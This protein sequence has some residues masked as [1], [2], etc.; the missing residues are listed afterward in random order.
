MSFKKYLSLLL[1]VCLCVSFFPIS[2]MGYEGEENI[3]K[4]VE[5]TAS[6]VY[7]SPPSDEAA[8]S[9]MSANGEGEVAQIGEMGYP[10]LSAAIA[11]VSG[12]S[13]TTITLL[14]NIEERVKIESTKNIR[15]DLNGHTISGSDEVIKNMGTLEM[16]GLIEGSGIITS[17]VCAVSNWGGTGSLTVNGGHYKS[18]LNEMTE[19]LMENGLFSFYFTDSNKGIIE[20]VQAVSEHTIFYSGSYSRINVNNCSVIKE[21]QTDPEDSK[22]SP[23][24]RISDS[25]WIEICG[26]IYTSDNVDNED[27]S[28]FYAGTG[29]ITVNSGSFT[30]NGDGIPLIDG[31]DNPNTIYINGGSFAGQ[32]EFNHSEYVD[33]E[34]MGG[35]Y[36]E[37]LASDI[38]NHPAY[39]ASGYQLYDNTDSDSATYTK[40]VMEANQYFKVGDENFRNFSDAL[41]KAEETASS[42]SHVTITMLQNYSEAVSYT[43]DQDDDGIILDL[44]GHTY[45]I[46]PYNSTNCS[47]TVSSG[48]DLTLRDSSQTGS[49]C[50]K[51]GHFA[52]TLYV[53]DGGKFTLDG[54]HI[55]GNHALYIGEGSEVHLN[56]GTVSTENSG[57]PLAVWGRATVFIDTAHVSLIQTSHDYYYQ[58]LSKRD[59]GF[60]PD[61]YATKNT[62]M[63]YTVS[64]GDNNTL[65]WGNATVN[66]I[67]YYHVIEG[68][69]STVAEVSVPGGTTGLYTSLAEAFNA[70]SSAAQEDTSKIVTV[71]L[72]K[73]FGTTGEVYNIPEQ[74]NGYAKIRFDLNGHTLTSTLTMGKFIDL[75]VRDSCLSG[76]K[77]IGAPCVIVKGSYKKF[78]LLS[79]KLEIAGFPD[80]SF[81]GANSVDPVAAGIYMD[82]DPA[83]SMTGGTIQLSDRF[84]TTGADTVAGIYIKGAVDTTSLTGGM[85]DVTANN[86]SIDTVGVDV[87]NSSYLTIGSD[88]NGPEI[89]ANTNAI[90]IGSG[91]NF[92]GSYLIKGG[93]LSSRKSSAILNEGSVLLTVEGKTAITGTTAL[94]V[95]KGLLNIDG[96]PALTGTDGSAVHIN[97]SGGTVSEIKFSG[98]PTFTSAAGYEQ[99]KVTPKSNEDTIP[100]ILS[101][102]NNYTVTSDYLWTANTDSNTNAKYPFKVSFAKPVITR[103]SLV[104]ASEIGVRFRVSFPENYNTDECR[105]DFEVVDGRTESMSFEKAQKIDNTN[106]YY[107]TCYINALELAEDI[108]ATLYYG[109]NQ[110][111]ED[112][113]SAMSY[114]T[115]VQQNMADNKELLNL[116]NA[117]QNYGYYMQQSGW[118]DDKPSHT[119]ILMKDELNTASID[120]AKDGV[121]NMKV[122]KELENSGITDAKFALSLNEKTS[123]RVS[124]K[125]D[126]ET[127]ILTS[128]GKK[129]T[130]NDETYYQFTTEKFGA[131]YLA[132]PYTVTVVTDKGTASVT[133][134]AMSYVHAILNGDFNQNEQKAMTAYYYYYKAADEYSKSGN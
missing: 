11:A 103:H 122:I 114:I 52:T 59:N 22:I 10:T 95:T 42:G 18:T 19:S 29:R 50:L 23:I 66:S 132:N 32:G 68:N 35:K 91:C 12:D 96:Q 49:G 85:I 76:G 24:F 128:G 36:S 90:R 8:A 84:D 129:R 65:I 14:Q 89:I 15:L 67:D 125:P 75:T 45:T 30:L 20:N 56:N 119:D 26:G 99:I 25:S 107:F 87:I 94:E 16:E 39:F 98:K 118:K 27:N 41:R 53:K 69:Q 37:I 3:V 93:C 97:H 134:S 55:N 115:N 31:A 57:Y 1:A 120:E 110:S 28:L 102:V 58:I 81:S 86:P 113:Y 21:A 48:G 127:T 54:A 6:E 82:G 47:F 124:F 72:L 83:V 70:A 111:L 5:K 126:N 46:M 13:Q 43:F 44:Y 100:A 7:E 73:D 117:L 64:G 9:L 33:V 74:E 92:E 40:M 2:A 121:S 133:A 63:N 77:I 130:I 123:I 109:D 105:M 4:T 38:E 104:L 79:G 60:F 51:S 80:S 17:G 101:T 71:T 88:N 108:K 116:V 61:I 112:H 78:T 62:D 106:D 131:A 34:I